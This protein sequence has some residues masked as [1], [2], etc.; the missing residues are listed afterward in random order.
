MLRKLA[1]AAVLVMGVASLA[2]AFQTPTPPA[3]NPGPG[4][5]PRAGA[6][7]GRGQMG[8]ITA[9]TGTT[10]TIKTMRG[11]EIKATIA[12]ETPVVKADQ[13]PGAI[14]DLK[15]GSFVAVQG[16]R[17][18]DGTVTA[19][20]VTISN[21]M[22]VGSIQAVAAKRITVRGMDNKPATYLITDKTTFRKGMQDAKIADFKVGDQVV[23]EYT[24]AAA[25]SIRTFQ[26][27]AGGGFGGQRGNRNGNNAAPPAPPAP[28]APAAAPGQ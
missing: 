8:V 1:I 14:A 25:L 6:R 27:G 10:Y 2:E 21:P 24:G 28:T 22:I 7:R 13:K 18:T 12:P 5:A 20:N 26:A 17:G 4:G 11:S 9:I 23:V 15:V 19:T 3:P 16:Q